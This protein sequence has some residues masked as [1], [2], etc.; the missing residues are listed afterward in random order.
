VGVASGDATGRPGQHGGVD[1][2]VA[3]NLG[4]F[5]HAGSM[6]EGTLQ[7]LKAWQSPV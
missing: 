3:G 4:A 6:G 5:K 7:V 2:I 1:R